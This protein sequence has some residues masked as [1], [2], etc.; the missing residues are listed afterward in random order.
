MSRLIPCLRASAFRVRWFKI[1]ELESSGTVPC[2]RAS[3]F[4]VRWFKVS[5]LEESKLLKTEDAL[6]SNNLCTRKSVGTTRS[7]VDP[8][9]RTDVKSERRMISA[10]ES[11]NGGP[12]LTWSRERDR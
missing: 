9:A 7:S 2:L 12:K 1:S 5:E 10:S 8:G 4:R 11:S 6:M 3:A